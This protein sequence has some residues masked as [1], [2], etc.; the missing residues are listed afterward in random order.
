MHGIKGATRFIPS[1]CQAVD[2]PVRSTTRPYGVV[3]FYDKVV[4]VENRSNTTTGNESVLRLNSI[5]WW[6][7]ARNFPL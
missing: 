7:G 3:V 6:N 2:Y 5:F 4:G 1:F